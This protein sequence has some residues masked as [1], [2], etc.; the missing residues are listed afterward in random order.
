MHVVVGADGVTLDSPNEFNRFDVVRRDGAD[1]T[2][3]I[4]EHGWGTVAESGDVM[5]SVARL[6]SAGPDDDAWRSGL[7]GMIGY[8][9]TKGWLDA[10]GT[11]IQAHIVDET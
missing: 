1:V 7:D 9:R 10:D 4:V 3:A 2:A 6:R 8:A 5:I 11:H